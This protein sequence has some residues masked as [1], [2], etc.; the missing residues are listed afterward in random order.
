MHACPPPPTGDPNAG[1]IDADSNAPL[2]CPPAIA[3]P[4]R[5]WCIVA[6]SPPSSCLG[7]NFCGVGYGGARCDTCSDGYYQRSGECVLCPA[8]PA[9]LFIGFAIIVL[10]AAMGAYWLNK[11]AV[12]TTTVA[13]GVDYF[14]VIAIFLGA[15][16]QW[17]E[18]VKELFNILSAF[19]LNIEVVAPECLA[20]GVTYK[21]KVSAIHII[22]N[23]Y[24]PLHTTDIVPEYV[25]AYTCLNQQPR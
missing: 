2:G 22:I 23:N 24:A 15:Q 19:N 7:S 9:A 18:P 3:I 10:A 14:Q 1:T 8:S 16:V 20:A 17:P 25:R 12:N 13:I 11:K 6:C 5:S 21:D 4:G